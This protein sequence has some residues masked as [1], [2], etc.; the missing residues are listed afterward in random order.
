MTGQVNPPRGTGGTFD[1]ATVNSREVVDF[2]FGTQ[3]SD[4]TN[5]LLVADFVLNGET[6]W[7]LPG[8]TVSWALG[9]QYR[10]DELERELPMPRATCDRRRARTRSSILP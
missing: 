3:G 9:A 2:I 8:G 10:E 7:Q 6:P 4:D 5:S 1:P